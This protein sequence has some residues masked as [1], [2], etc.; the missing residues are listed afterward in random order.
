M[1]HPTAIINLGW[2]VYANSNAYIVAKQKVAYFGR[3]QNSI[4]LH[5]E[6]NGDARLGEDA[7]RNLEERCE[8]LDAAQ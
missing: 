3:K 6:M 2:S 8:V 7:A 4:G 5:A 1:V